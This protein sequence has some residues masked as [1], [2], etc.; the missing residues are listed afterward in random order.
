VIL[1]AGCV[2]VGPID[3]RYTPRKGVQ[4]PCEETIRYRPAGESGAPSYEVVLV[5]IDRF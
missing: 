2:I 4:I 3:F 1:G 5:A